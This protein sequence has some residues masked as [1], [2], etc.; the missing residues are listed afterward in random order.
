MAS[1]G[2]AEIDPLNLGFKPE[3]LKKKYAEERD[4]RLRK[5]GA[6]QVRCLGDVWKS[7]N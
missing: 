3:E 5:E 7:R 6:R 1:R 2:V 4:K